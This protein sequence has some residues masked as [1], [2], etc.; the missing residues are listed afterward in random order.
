[1]AASSIAL[2]TSSA[3]TRVPLPATSTRGSGLGSTPRSDLPHP[4]GEQR[5]L[6]AAAG[7]AAD[8]DLLRADHEVDVDLALVDPRQVGRVRDR[9]RI[10][11]A[12]RKVA[13][14]V[15]VEERVEEGPAELADTALA[16]D[17][18]HLAEP[19]GALVGGAALAQGLG[20]RVRLDLDGATP[21]EADPE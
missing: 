18:R 11:V 21:L 12:E 19:R 15:L 8:G 5:D 14:R 13:R 9:V 16:V 17:E 4:A 2:R 7:H 1:P 6:V 10:R 3:S 20:V